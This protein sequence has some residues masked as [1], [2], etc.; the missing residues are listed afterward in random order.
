[1]TAAPVL[2]V[3]FYHFA[4][5]APL[6]LLRDELLSRCQQIGARG[7]VLLAEEGVNG[8]LAAAPDALDA[9]LAWLVEARPALATMPI[10]RSRSSALP[11]R[12]LNVKIKPEIVT[13][14]VPGVDA[15]TRTA[16][17][18]DPA[19]LRDWLRGDQEV[20]LVDIRNDFE[21][22]RGTFHGAINPQTTAFHE[23]PQ[24]AL[25][26]REAW[27]GRKIVT[28]CTGGI[29]CEKA[30][31]WMLDEGFGE[32]YQ[33]DGGVLRYF[34]QVEDADKDWRGELFVF[35][36]RV[37]VDTRLAPVPEDRAQRDDER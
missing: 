14:R 21:W 2:N 5:L 16:P 18:L 32:V 30:T 27:A 35:D 15:R 37:A 34:E 36:E 26:Q 22:R 7:T 8:M 9:L 11:F 12:R 17:K 6:E 3:A 28:F 23:F 20:V 33:L 10:K 25:A 13:L 31:S 24:F 19:T 4:D 29:R 1:M